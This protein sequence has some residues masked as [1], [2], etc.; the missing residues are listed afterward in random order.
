M[1]INSTPLSTRQQTLVNYL[2]V[3]PLSLNFR[4]VAQRDRTTLLQS[5]ADEGHQAVRTLN[6]LPCIPIL[7]TTCFAI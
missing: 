3:Q 2:S 7:V 5:T 6:D 4:E 1:V